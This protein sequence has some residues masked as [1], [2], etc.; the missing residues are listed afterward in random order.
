MSDADGFPDEGLRPPFLCE[1]CATPLE[2]SQPDEQRPE[3][4]LGVCPACGSWFLVE[5]ADTGLPVV[6]RLANA[7]PSP[8]RSSPT[9]GRAVRRRG[10]I[11]PN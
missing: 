2:M 11:P 8:A 6:V 9:R 10:T 7:L 3:R 1:G 5:A 4:L